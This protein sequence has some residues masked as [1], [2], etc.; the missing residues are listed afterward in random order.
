[1]QVKFTK[2]M[3][4]GTVTK[5]YTNILTML[6]W[7]RMCCDHPALACTNAVPWEDAGEAAKRAAAECDRARIINGL[8]WV[9][10]VKKMQLDKAINA[11]K[12]EKEVSS[13]RW[14]YTIER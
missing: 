9:E 12:A 3:K 6:L 5:N 11:I 10:K 8:D 1:M 14:N 2:F 13:A 4:A 7:L